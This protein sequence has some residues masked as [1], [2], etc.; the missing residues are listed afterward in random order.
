MSVSFSL[1]AS[2]EQVIDNS[3]QTATCILSQTQL[4]VPFY[5]RLVQQASTNSYSAYNCA[6]VR[7]CLCVCVCVCVF[8]MLQLLGKSARVVGFTVG[9][10]RDERARLF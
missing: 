9:L 1:T 7:A 2:L 10:Y 6:S 5:T 3:V 8:S 4:T